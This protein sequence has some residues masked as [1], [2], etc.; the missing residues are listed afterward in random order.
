MERKGRFQGSIW[1]GIKGLRWVLGEMGKL[2]TMSATQTGVFQFM[3]DGYRTL[4]FSCLSNRGGRFV[5]LSEYHG[6]SHKGGIRVPEGR[7]GA[8]WDRFGFELRNYF[9]TS[10]DRRASPPEGSGIAGVARAPIMTARGNRKDRQPN[11]QPSLES[12]KSRKSRGRDP[13]RLAPRNHSRFILSTVE[14]RPT[15]HFDFKWTQGPNTLR[16]SK[17]EGQSREAKWVGLTNADGPSQDNASDGPVSGV[18]LKCGPASEAQQDQL[19]DQNDEEASGELRVLGCM[20]EEGEFQAADNSI[21]DGEGEESIPMDFRSTDM[22]ESEVP[23]KGEVVIPRDPSDMVRADLAEQ[24][25]MVS[26]AVGDLPTSPTTAIQERE[27][28]DLPFPPICTPLAMIVPSTAPDSVGIPLLQGMERSKWVKHQYRGMCKMLGFP[29]DS[30]E[31][32]CLDLLQRIEDTRVL[33]NREVGPKRVL[34][35]G[36]KGAREL[37]N[38]TSSVNYEGKRHTRC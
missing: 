3:R 23:M 31:Q 26:H 34:S 20:T 17:N 16:I 7:H 38:L 15:R 14:P 11:P 5:E 27:C 25:L 29:L 2:K 19:L 35:S 12:R 9:L 33:T 6:G 36:T 22:E 18:E 37:K 28:A 13:P 21:G 4:E 32:Q 24:Q 8:G 1:L 30:H 10:L